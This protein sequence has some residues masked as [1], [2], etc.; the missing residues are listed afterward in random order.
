MNLI[1]FIFYL[2]VVVEVWEPEESD[3]CVVETCEDDSDDCVV[4]TCEDDS[5]V[6]VEL[7]DVETGTDEDCAT[8]W[9]TFTTI[10]VSGETFPPSGE[11]VTPKTQPVGLPG[12]SI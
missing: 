12:V 6:E 7:S 1:L 11:G 2:V 3:D 4:E 9:V 8:A 5:K 10:G